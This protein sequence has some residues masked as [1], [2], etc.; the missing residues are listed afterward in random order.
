MQRRCRFLFLFIQRN[1]SRAWRHS[2]QAGYRLRIR[3]GVFEVQ[4]YRT[5]A[6]LVSNP[7]PFPI[8]AGYGSC[9]TGHL[10]GSDA[11]TGPSRQSSCKQVQVKMPKPFD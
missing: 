5:P 10:Y 8:R 2:R 7:V 11:P 3:L 4:L 6:V 1:L 9:P